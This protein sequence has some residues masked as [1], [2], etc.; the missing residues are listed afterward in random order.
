MKK[1]LE[2]NS[3]LFMFIALFFLSVIT[4]L[5]IM[6]FRF[7]K[8][9]MTQYEDSIR[10]V[11]VNKTN[12]FFNDLRAATEGAAR[13]LARWQEDR[14]RALGKL[15]AFDSRITGAYIINASG[16]ITHG[17]P[18]PHLKVMAGQVLQLTG[19]SILGVHNNGT[20]QVVVTVVTH[21]D[22]EWLALDYRINDFQQ[23]MIQEFLGSICKVAVFD[24]N[25][26]PVVWPFEP[27]KLDQFTGREEKFHLDMPYD[28][29]SVQL[30]QPPWKLYFFQQ[31]NNFDTYRIITI[32]F[33][34]FALYCCLYQLVVEL[35]RVNSARSY[36]ENIDFTIFNYIN[37]GVII[38]NNAG[39]IIFANMA[40]HEVFSG[41]KTILKDMPLKELLGHI[42]D[43]CDGKNKYGTLT[44]KMSDR[45]LEA[46]HSPLIKKGKVLGAITV[47][48]SGGKEE[49][50]CRNFLSKLIESLPLGVVHVDRNHKVVQANLMAR[51]YLGSVEQG[52]SID[53]VDPELA[54]FI[55]R[56]MGSSSI[57]PVLLASRNL[58]AEV[59]YIY[60][61]D[62]NYDG[63]LVIVNEPEEG[64]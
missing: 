32:M 36:F 33:L 6:E 57:K 4:A 13:Q 23:E 46:I 10:Q 50:T 30:E 1:Y 38:S 49:K 17:T 31:E 39:R 12:L 34:L 29:S 58:I 47:L 64:G 37:E 21:L 14:N 51:C 7:L 53:G 28:V 22:G 43:T 19:T 55:Y 8:G 45:L 44:L 60:D 61:E 35:W 5:F 27:E 56:N 40:A 48:G 2:A 54:G 42:G 18:D 16:R 15:F 3:V 26:F 24:Q 11:A 52:M 20:G 63:A 62:G 9:I 25:N 41:R 59:I